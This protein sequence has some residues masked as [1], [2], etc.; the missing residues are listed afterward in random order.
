M[1]K[2]S[3]YRS[4]LT[5]LLSKE[6]AEAIEGDLIEESIDNGKLWYH[7]EFCRLVFSVLYAKL[8]DQIQDA[9]QSQ[10]MTLH[11]L[12]MALR[13]ITH[14]LVYSFVAIMSLAVGMTV[15]LLILSFVNHE[16]SFDSDFPDSDRIY[17]LI[18]V[19]SNTGS[20]IA[21]F[22]NP[23]GV[24]F[25]RDFP[26]VES[27][28]Q[29]YSRESLLT[30][31]GNG[32]Y[33]TLSMVSENFFEMFP[34]ETI[35][36]DPVSTLANP[37]GA[38]LTE[39]AAIQIY[40]RA[41][42]IGEL[43]SVNNELEYR[44]GAVVSNNP[45]NT[46]FINNFF[47]GIENAPIITGSAR[48]LEHPRIATTYNYFKLAPDT[49]IPDL[50]RKT[51]EY[52]RA[53]IEPQFNYRVEYQALRDIHF[54]ANLESEMSALDELIGVSKPYRSRVDLFIY[55]AVALLTLIVA[56]FNFVNLLIFQA[57]KRT[58]EIGI[59][60]TLGAS[61]FQIAMLFLAESIA[62]ALVA[63][64]IAILL[65]QLLGTYFANV[66]GSS[67]NSGA[68]VPLPDVKLILLSAAIVGFIAGIYPA[69][70][71]AGIA[72]V[73]ALQDQC[74]G[75]ISQFRVRSILIVI[76]FSVCVGLISCAA[77][78]NS[79][80]DY[81]LSKP[82][83]YEPEN[84]VVIENL[85]ISRAGSQFELMRDEML[86]D[87]NVYEVAS[88]TAIPTGQL[89]GVLVYFLVGENLEEPYSLRGVQV[90]EGFFDVLGINIVY[91]RTLNE[92]LA[93]DRGLRTE[94]DGGTQTDIS[95]VINL[96]AVRAI[97]WN[98]PEE[99]IGSRIFRG[100]QYL[101]IVG[102]AEDAHF[103]S[104]RTPIEPMFFRL[105]DV[106]NEMLV[107]I[108][109]GNVPA[110]LEAIDRAWNNHVPNYP[111]E[112]SFLIDRYRSAY[113]GELRIRDVFSSLSAIAILLSCLGLYA[114]AALLTELRTKEIGIRKILGA[115][116][117]RLVGLLSWEITRFILFAN[118]IAWPVA[119][120][121]MERWLSNFAFRVDV[122]IT[123]LV[124]AS[125]S[126][127][128]LAFFTT[129]YKS[130]RVALAN[131]VDALRYE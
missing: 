48:V 91:G 112:R 29:L 64:T 113:A 10:L 49:N 25:A 97:G 76:Q 83:G 30:V 7:A 100:N 46:H 43:F 31:N 4:I 95:T 77:I 130:Y 70:T 116:V 44:V 74:I 61:R 125:I 98:N 39:A 69:A 32:Q 67:M 11:Y 17:R 90:S 14:R 68:L 66:V 59:R 15:C 35:E 1:T 93:S 80:I 20:R 94:V 85:R 88:S 115:T 119:W 103:S 87:A 13:S 36:G 111:I 92:S 58:K 28:T 62:M 23:M 108:N 128:V 118:L 126:T 127:F 131:P 78:I 22:F 104:I 122:S 124:L 56:G 114:F 2:K 84:V 21:T 5:R 75:A 40:G 37:T 42:V 24:S 63:S 38:V 16:R 99:A 72:P 53:N 107:R 26:E 52:I 50:Q 33:R 120:L 41:D 65:T 3:V 71:N 110:A 6:R 8:L 81:A 18:R 55:G 19:N 27:F 96:A 102:I 106:R 60:R 47:V 12:K 117:S 79:Q 57:S 51:Y 34:A 73:T 89:G 54:T 109:P 129:A 121:S 123:I 9:K 45:R 101:T 82:L 105:D 86:R